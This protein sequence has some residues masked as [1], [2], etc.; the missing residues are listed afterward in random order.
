MEADD[1][2][3]IGRPCELLPVS[4]ALGIGDAH[5][6]ATRAALDLPARAAA[7]V[8]PW[9]AARVALRFASPSC[10]HSGF[11]VHCPALIRGHR[12]LD[13]E[14]LVGEYGRTV[15]S[16][17]RAR[18]SSARLPPG[19]DGQRCY[20]CAPDP[21]R[22]FARASAPT[23]MVRL[24]PISSLKRGRRPVPYMGTPCRRSCCGCGGRRA[25]FQHDLCRHYGPQ[26]ASLPPPR[27]RALRA[28]PQRLRVRLHQPRRHCCR[29]PAP[30]G[31]LS[32]DCQ[33]AWR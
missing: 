1:P 24:V 6:N 4:G 33:K 23:Q 16:A 2:C 5:A 3:G 21:E 28:R 12:V 14:G 26:P 15:P 20:P 30:M 9:V 31:A 32:P 8:A 19:Q 25:P 18:S 7:W 27:R 17:V 22:L 10:R 13:K 11:S 29:V